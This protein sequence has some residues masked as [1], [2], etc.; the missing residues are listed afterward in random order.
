M[1][2]TYELAPDLLIYKKST[3]YVG[4]IYAKI[5]SVIEEI[6]REV[7]ADDAKAFQAFNLGL[8]LKL[9]SDDLD[10]EGK[11]IVDYTEMPQ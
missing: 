5:E 9:F 4:G 3:S 7:T 11:R 1:E 6:P 10:V 2:A 8:A